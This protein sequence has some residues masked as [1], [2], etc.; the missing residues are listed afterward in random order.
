MLDDEGLAI[1]PFFITDFPR[2]SRF[3]NNLK[4]RYLQHFNHEA[5]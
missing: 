1:Q 2:N 4:P 3:C 5:L